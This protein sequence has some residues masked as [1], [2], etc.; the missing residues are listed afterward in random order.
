VS[1]QPSQTKE[2]KQFPCESCGAPLTFSIGAQRLKCAHCGFEKPLTFD[3]GTK[4]VSDHALAEGL[5][6]Q[7]KQRSERSEA[8]QELGCAACGAV[9]VFAGSLTS[10]ACAYCDTPLQLKNA[11]TSE[12][13]LPVDGLCTFVV[14]KTQAQ[15]NLKRWVRWRWFA[16]SAFT[17][18]GVEGTS[19]RHGGGLDGVY[20]PFFT[21]DAMT[22]TRFRGER[23]DAYWVST[24]SGNKPKRQRRVDWTSKAGAFH[25]FFEDLCVPALRSLPPKLLRGLEP[26]PVAA[27]AKGGSRLIPFTHGAL[28]GKRAHTYELKLSD[29]FD[30][31]KERIHEELS[32]DVKACIGGDEQRVHS[33]TT[34][35]S[36][37][38]F[39]H[40][41]LPVWILAYRYEGRPYRVVVNAV[42][43]QVNGERPWSIPKIMAAVVVVVALLALFAY[44]APRDPE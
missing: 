40:V 16:P 21:F 44:F 11:H 25:R 2:R 33:Q 9:V 38:T 3:E 8:Q 34:G 13:P 24:T 36:A 35:F 7:A 41:L 12:R 39:K 4:P 6:K 30:H 5:A 27:T 29:C 17:K 42:T 19:G 10:S 28:A 26:W 20:M 18:R 31:A 14:E 37:L 1:E 23:G 15:E 22:F 43:G 32:K